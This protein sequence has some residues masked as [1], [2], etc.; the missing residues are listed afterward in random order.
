VIINRPQRMQRHLPQTTPRTRSARSPSEV[1]TNSYAMV[2]IAIATVCFTALAAAPQRIVSIIPAT[3]EMIFAMGE[4]ARVVGVGNY[5]HF[6]AQVSG[7][8]RVGGLLDPDVERIIALRPDLV[9]VY[10][11]QQELRERLERAG[12]PF[13]PYKHRG[14][15]DVTET[16]RDLGER[17]GVSA[18]ATAVASAIERD[19]AAIRTSVAGLPRPRTLLVLG[20]DP[21]TLRNIF[22]S[23]GYG[24]LHD[25]LE[26]AGG[27]DVYSDVKR[28]SVEVSTE[29]ILARRPDV[30]VELR[31]G[32]NAGARETSQD[33]EVWSALGSVPA[34][35]NHRIVALVGDEFVVPGPRVVDA[36]RQLARTLHSE[37]F[38]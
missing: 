5:D 22:A 3:T 34:V 14:L 17:L 21:S 25:M 37:A 1:V 29:M 10:A 2:I 30:I 33:L 16:I 13:Y 15:A 18:R 6:P 32:D 27:D 8:P 24:F 38:K 4:G 20:R 7:L 11:T 35:K 12:I 9:I 31:Y 19:L 26:V 36:T 28:E 23:G